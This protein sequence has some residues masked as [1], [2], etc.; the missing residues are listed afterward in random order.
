M[1][2]SE[3]IERL[4]L[5]PGDLP[6]LIA[7][8]SE[9]YVND[10]LLTEDGIRIEKTEWWQWFQPVDYKNGVKHKGKALVLYG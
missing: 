10:S 5:L 1:T 4:K 8:W 6:V 3:F 7:D 2:V 9:Q